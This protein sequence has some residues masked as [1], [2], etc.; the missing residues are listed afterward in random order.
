MKR[1]ENIKKRKLEKGPDD[2][3]EMELEVCGLPTVM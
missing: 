3:G 2:N 1:Q